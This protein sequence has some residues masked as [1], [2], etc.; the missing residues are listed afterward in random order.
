MIAMILALTA[1]LEVN[2]RVSHAKNNDAS[3]SNLSDILR[4]S[5]GSVRLMT[6]KDAENFCK[7]QGM[8]LPTA[9]EIALYSQGL[10]AKGVNPL[11][12]SAIRNL[13]SP[14]GCSVYPFS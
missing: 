13:E 2:S 1:G 7:S 12:S 11:V 6:R 3:E 4:N 5:D 9:R 10:G 8:R 14:Y